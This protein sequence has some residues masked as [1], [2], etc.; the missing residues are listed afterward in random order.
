MDQCRDNA[1]NPIIRPFLLVM[2]NVLN[3]LGDIFP[4]LCQATLWW[5]EIHLDVKSTRPSDMVLY[6]QKI[7]VLAFF[8]LS[9]ISLL[10]R[11]GVSPQ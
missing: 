5:N 11:K 9:K 2:E 7:S 1:D 10:T 4:L 3:C 6:E 8:I